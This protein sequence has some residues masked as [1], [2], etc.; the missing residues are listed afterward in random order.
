[1]WG[2]RLDL[3]ERKAAVVV[4]YEHTPPRI[5]LSPLLDA[6]EVVATRIAGI[7]LGPRVQVTR[8]GL[9]HPVHQQLL[10][11]AW[12]VLALKGSTS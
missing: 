8:S 3:R 9:C 12:Q 2:T 11:V 6:F 1:V 4:G 7:H 5:S 10:V